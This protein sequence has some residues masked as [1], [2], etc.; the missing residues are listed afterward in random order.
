MLL[1]PEDKVYQLIV[2]AEA[3]ALKVT[4][5]LLHL[6]ASVV[7]VIAGRALTVAATAVR[8]EVVQPFAVAST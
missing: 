5:P 4:V 6:L 7:P 2:P 3:V 1:P 8:E